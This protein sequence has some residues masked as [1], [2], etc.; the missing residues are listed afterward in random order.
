MTAVA[1]GQS[2]AVGA[3]KPRLLGLLGLGLGGASD[4]DS[5]GI[6]TYSQAARAVG[7]ISSAG[8]CFSATP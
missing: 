4:D 2:A 7:P 1:D 8:Q 5:I 6:A 3:G